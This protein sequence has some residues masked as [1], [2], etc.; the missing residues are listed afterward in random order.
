MLNMRIL[1]KHS[2]LFVLTLL[3]LS[4]I[5]ILSSWPIRSAMSNLHKREEPRQIEYN[6][7]TRASVAILIPS[8]STSTWSNLD[9]TA[10]KTRL[11]PS[12]IRTI[13]LEERTKFQF[14]LYLAFDHDDAF[15]MR[16]TPDNATLSN[17]LQLP[18]WIDLHAEFYTVPEHRIP[19]NEVAND[20]YR[21]GVDFFCRVND[22]TVFT[23]SGWVTLAIRALESFDPPLIGVVGPTFKEGNTAIL[24]HDF[25]SRKHIDIFGVYYSTEFDNWWTDDWITDVYKPGRSLKLTEWQ[26]KHDLAMHGTRYTVDFSQ[27]TLLAAELIKGRELIRKFVR[28]QVGKKC[29][30]PSN[31]KFY[32]QSNEDKAMYE[33]FYKNPLKCGGVFVEI[34]ALDGRRY[35]NSL[36]F[37]TSL[38][39]KCLLVEANPE[40]A[41]HLKLNRP[42]A[43]TV[44]AAMC[45]EKEVQ[46][47]GSNAVGGVVSSMTQE[48]IDGWIQASDK[49]VSVPCMQ[50]KHLFSKHNITHIDIF[51]IDVEGGELDVLTVMDWSVD[52]DF[53]II[54][55]SRER[56]NQKSQNIVQL[57]DAHGYVP[58]SWDLKSWCIP[59]QDCTTNTV[60]KRVQRVVSFSVYGGESTRYTDGALANAHLMPE[61]Y[62]GW[63]MRVYYD[64]TVPLFVIG[65]LGMY[66]YVELINMTGSRIKNKILWRTLVAS[67]PLVDRYIIRNADSRLSQR[68]R[69]A[70]EE[71]IISGT[72]FHVIRDHPLHL[73]YPMNGGLWGGT[74]ETIPKLRHLLEDKYYDELTFL[75]NKIWPIARKDVLQHD[76]I[77][78]NE[79]W[80]NTKLLLSSDTID[81]FIGDIWIDGVRAS[82]ELFLFLFMKDR[83]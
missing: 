13:T 5:C 36:F 38:D 29:I 12:L 70:V 43:W 3:P 37:E 66:E 73:I 40:N 44:H 14:R 51:V 77:S 78:C 8:H 2:V 21:H 7:T 32:S 18:S 30:A 55:M 60:F 26:V 9:H 54:E 25:V 52:V 63:T 57:L 72:K 82:Y 19:F 61:I 49:V 1:T 17:A 10:L 39:W 68:E 80:G 83:I 56:N 35:S 76:S 47:R 15:W 74:Q 4:S 45:L 81:Q 41:R 79:R 75:R 46:F 6:S 20:A 33:Q 50:W 53:F 31:P 58:V 28:N 24:T 42:N 48:H 67:D 23:T 59:N 69:N 64:N 71:W 65:M 11:I 27:Q 62:P 34:G 16:H 22:D